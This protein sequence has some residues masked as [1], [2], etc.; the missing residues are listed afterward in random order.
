M[1]WTA[2]VCERQNGEPSHAPHA[3]LI[4]QGSLPAAL[5]PAA[6]TSSLK[7]EAVTV[8]LVSSRAARRWAIDCA[9]HHVWLRAAIEPRPKT[10]EQRSCGQAKG[11][12]VVER[13]KWIELDEQSRCFT[14]S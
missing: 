5:I 8:Q 6:I 13:A 4:E 14:L 11:R 9:Q 1:E 12:D 7:D 10:G 3:S 2:N